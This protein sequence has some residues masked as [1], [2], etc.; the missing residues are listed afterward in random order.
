MCLRRCFTFGIGQK[1]CR[2][3]VQG[4]ARVSKGT[5]EFLTEGERL[6]PKVLISS[7]IAS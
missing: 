4:L 2:R 3:L 5:A 7:C 6:Q 1:A